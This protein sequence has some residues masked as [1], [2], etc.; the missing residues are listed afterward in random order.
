MLNITYSMNASYEI[1]NEITV[2]QR[3]LISN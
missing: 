2:E 3:K 1:Q